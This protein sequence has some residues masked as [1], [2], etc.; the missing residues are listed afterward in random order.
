MRPAWL[1]RLRAEVFNDTIICRGVQISKLIDIIENI[2]PELIWYVADLQTVGYQFEQQIRAM[3]MRV[4]FATRMSELALG[5]VQFRSGV[6]LGVSSEIASPAFREGGSWTEDEEFA[7]LGDSTVEIRAFDTS[8]IDIG[9]SDTSLLDT[10]EG[11]IV[12]GAPV[13]R[14]YDRI[15]F[16]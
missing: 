11:A 2:I 6:F 3:P 7:D 16:R 12:K 8:Y 10:I 9:S 13:G 1:L 14:G 5:V 15:K 4:G